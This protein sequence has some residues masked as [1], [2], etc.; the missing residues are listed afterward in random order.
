MWFRCRSEDK[1]D[2]MMKQE[3]LTSREDQHPKIK[4]E[5]ITT[6]LR[7]LSRI[8]TLFLSHSFLAQNKKAVLSR[9]QI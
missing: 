1:K 5:K 3:S 7:L 2:E 4:S 8:P 9:S 6:N